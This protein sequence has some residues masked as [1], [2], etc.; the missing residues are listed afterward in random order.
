MLE[1]F[2]LTRPVQIPMLAFN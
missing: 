1:D 2:G